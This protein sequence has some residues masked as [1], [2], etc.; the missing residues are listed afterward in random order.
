MYSLLS[1]QRSLIWKL[2]RMNKN[3]I[4]SSE[5]A[6]FLDVAKYKSKYTLIKEKSFPGVENISEAS[7][8]GSFYENLSISVARSILDPDRDFVWK[9]VGHIVD[10]KSNL[11]CSPD[12]LFWN[13]KRF[14]GLEVKTPYSKSLPKKP[15]EIIPEHIL[16]CFTSIYLTKAH[17]WFLFYYEVSTKKYK[18]FQIFRNDDIW[19]KILGEIQLNMEK[20]KETNFENKINRNRQKEGEQKY[21]SLFEMIWIIDHSQSSTLR[22]GVKSHNPSSVS[23]DIPC[24]NVSCQKE[25]RPPLLDK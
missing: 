9:K 11:G 18:L 22:I 3:R 1:K 25:H 21:K 17:S 20:M 19:K 14:Y 2:F 7:R 16:Q 12:A 6:S 13:E 23:F 5:V 10:Y 8:Y 15:S 24:Q 4:C